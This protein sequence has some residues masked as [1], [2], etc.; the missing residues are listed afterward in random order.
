MLKNFLKNFLLTLTRLYKRM[1]LR[2]S[3][4]D[5]QDLIQFQIRIS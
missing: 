5:K 4:I 1:L 3:M 2:I